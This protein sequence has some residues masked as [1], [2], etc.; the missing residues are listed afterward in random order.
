MLAARGYSL[1]I[2]DVSPA[3]LEDTRLTIEAHGT[4]V[5]SVQGDV[6]S[7]DVRAELARL[8]EQ[9]GGELDGLVNNAGV[10]SGL[11]IAETTDE[12]WDHLMGVNAKAM[13]F[14]IKDLLPYLR[15]AKGSVVNLSSTAGLVAFPSMPAYVASKTACVGLTRALAMDLAADEIRVNA[16]CPATIDTPMPRAYLSGVP[17]EARA[18]AE[19]AFFARN[20]IKRFGTPDEVASAIVYLLSRESSFVTG[21][22]FPVDGGVTAW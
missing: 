15:E 3:S 22:A 17:E 4:P 9:W 12:V 14:L 19:K 1:L 18:D 5:A 21:V 16:V 13:F 10:I 11:P 8:I 7:P 2:S 20:L 6:G